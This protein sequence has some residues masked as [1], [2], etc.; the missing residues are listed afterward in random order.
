M[1]SALLQEVCS[2]DK[3][4]GM[5]PGYAMVDEE[6]KIILKA[7]WCRVVEGRSDEGE[8]ISIGFVTSALTA[9]EIIGDDDPEFHPSDDTSYLYSAAVIE[10]HHRE[11]FGHLLTRQIVEEAKRAGYRYLALHVPRGGLVEALEKNL[12][13]IG[14]HDAP[15][16]WQSVPDT[17]LSPE[18][19]DVVCLL[20]EL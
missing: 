15:D 13:V 14:K 10:K 4:S 7:R 1:T 6:K 11:G 18:H 9:K 12:N 5:P 20:I 8:L 3:E 2:F 16:F 17:E 19:R